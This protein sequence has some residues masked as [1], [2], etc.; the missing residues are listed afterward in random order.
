MDLNK[1]T[2]PDKLELYSFEWSLVR[3]VVAAAT[4]ILSGSVPIVYRLFSYSFYPLYT[5]LN[6]SWIISGLSAGYLLYRW[7]NGGQKLFGKKDQKD[8][9][10]FLVM[11]VSGINLGIV[12]LLGTNI[13]MSISSARIVLVI[14][15]VAYLASAYHLHQ[16]WQENGK[17]LFEEK[18]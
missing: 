4:L 8:M 14:V 6:L 10:A 7:H 5:L 9:A 16:R 17:K 13:G 18:A 11:G 1:L 3:L 15:G 2:K 12:G